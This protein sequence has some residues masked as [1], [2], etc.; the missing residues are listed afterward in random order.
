MLAWALLAEL[1]PS[2]VYYCGH[3]S[4]WLCDPHSSPAIKA[5]L[6]IA[7]PTFHDKEATALACWSTL[8]IT[9]GFCLIKA[10]IKRTLHHRFELASFVILVTRSFAKV[11]RTTSSVSNSPSSSYRH[12]R[13]RDDLRGHGR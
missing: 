5:H 10:L 11:T 6:S 2:S 3:N 7:P 12:G 13:P 9:K 8:T 1:E 4:K